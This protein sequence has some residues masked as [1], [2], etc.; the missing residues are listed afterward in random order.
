MGGGG[1]SSDYVSK[2]GSKEVI[3]HAEL[4]SASQSN[5]VSKKL[6]NFTLA[7][8]KACH[9]EDER[10]EDVAIAKSLNINEITTQ[11]SIAR[12][13]K[14]LSETNLTTYRLNDLASVLDTVFSRFTSH[15][16]RKRVAYTLAEGA[17]HVDTC[18]GKRKIAF[19]L[20]E[21]LI[22]LGIIGVVASLTLPS[23]IHQYRKK[24]LETQFKTAYSFINQ[25]LVMTKQD[26]GSNSLFDDYTVYNSEQGYLYANEFVK[27]FYKRLKVVGNATLKS[28]DYSI[29]SDGNVKRYT[30]GKEFVFTTPDKLLENGMTIRASVG[31]NYDGSKHIG[32]VVDINGNKGPNRSGHD[33]FI[34]K[35]KDSSDKLIGSKKIRDYTEDELGDLSSGGIN[36]LLGMPCSRYSKQSA[37]GLGC[38][39]Y[40]IND[41]C[42]DD[43]TK[44]YWECLPR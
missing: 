25:A 20:A 18:D 5:E 19:T 23:V 8:K 15:F 13:D 41:I 17:T 3:R 4:V 12:N 43:E 2:F 37:N 38:T 34:F 31:G 32:V 10:S 42:P 6:R 35:I 40:A 26:L 21:V 1:L 22:T 33:L 14:S 36:N 28:T 27:A 11:S 30:N 39:W 24:A 44:G 16:S 29:Y 7:I 9:C